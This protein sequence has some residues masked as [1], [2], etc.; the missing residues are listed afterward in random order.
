M[1]FLKFV[2]PENIAH[3]FVTTLFLLSGQWTAFL[4]NAPLLAFNV[5]KYDMLSVVP[6]PSH[7]LTHALKNTK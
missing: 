3:A 7:D 5:N 6:C 2:L 4:L 1:D